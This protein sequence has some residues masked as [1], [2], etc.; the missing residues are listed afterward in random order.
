LYGNKNDEKGN[1]EK[2]R[3]EKCCGKE[4]L[5]PYAEDGEKVKSGQ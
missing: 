4:S 3:V 2:Y 5:A 1:C